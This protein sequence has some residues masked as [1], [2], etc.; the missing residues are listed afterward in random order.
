[1]ENLDPSPSQFLQ[2]SDKL[3]IIS[4]SL[5]NSVLFLVHGHSKGT[6]LLE[7]ISLFSKARRDTE[8]EV[9]LGSVSAV[10]QHPEQDEW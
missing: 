9:N 5:H 8:S 2:I 7:S 1:M 6:G 3:R 10:S 4:I